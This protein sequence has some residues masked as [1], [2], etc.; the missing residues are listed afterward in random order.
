MLA[1][2][3]RRVLLL[4]PVLLVVTLVTFF[5][6][7]VVPGDPARLV[8][9]LNAPQSQ[10]DRMRHE[11]GLDRP[12][13]EQYGSYMSDLAQGDLGEALSN[14]ET[15][16]ANLEEAFPATLELALAALAISILVGVPLGVIAAA[17]RGRFVDHVSRL[18]AIL[19]VA[20][21][22]FV[23]GIVLLLLLYYELGIFPSGNRVSTEVVAAHPLRQ[24]TGLITVDALL[25]GNFRVFVDALWHLALPA[26]A[27]SLATVARVVRTTRTSMVEVLRE[28]YVATARAKGVPERRVI[29]RHALRNALIPVATIVGISFGY[30]LGGALLVEQIFDWPGLGSY[31]LTSIRQLDYNSIQ[32]IT[33]IATLAFVLVNL[34]VDLL[35][36]RLDPR[37]RL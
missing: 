23:I 27:L 3:L 16:A 13:V 14:G 25:A 20:L 24:V 29:W 1:F 6:S 33:L 26:F 37:I 15:V 32:G 10:V 8:A 28:P 36:A 22:V 30:L 7:H 31:A 9:G 19:G 18:I 21:P 17:R 34:A 5:L 4:I 2:T 11:L 12:I 35:Y